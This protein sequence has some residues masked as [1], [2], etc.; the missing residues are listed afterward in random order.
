M[1]STV[2]A[3]RLAWKDPSQQPR[4]ERGQVSR[5]DR[6]FAA[7]G[8]AHDRNLGGCEPK[9]AWTNDAAAPWFLP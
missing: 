5:L 9:S 6:G 8:Q 2:D 1:K 3:A 4:A 7:A